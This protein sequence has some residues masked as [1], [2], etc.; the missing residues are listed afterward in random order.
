MNNEAL[1][2]EGVRIDIRQSKPIRNITITCDFTIDNLEGAD[3]RFEN[4]T[5]NRNLIIKN[6]SISDIIFDNCQ[7][8]GGVY[9]QSINCRTLEFANSTFKEKALITTASI[10]KHFTFTRPP[11][12]KQLYLTI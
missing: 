8:L 7:F 5:F 2:L 11:M 4:V 9:L 6:I 3:I 1:I 12:R 10:E